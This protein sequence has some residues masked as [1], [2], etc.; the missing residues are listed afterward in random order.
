M[1]IVLIGYRG[2]GKSTVARLLS[3]QLQWPLVATDQEIVAE[4]G[5]SIPRIVEAHG[6]DHFRDL[7]ARIVARVAA[8]DQVVIDTGGGVIVRDENVELLRRNGVIV[9][10]KADLHTIAARIQDDTERPSL[11]GSK[12]FLE[13]IEEVLQERTPRYAK[14]AELAIDTGE[15]S[16][17]SIARRIFAHLEGRAAR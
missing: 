9:W 11:T 1:N 3:A 15:E 6:W 8:R 16:P 13:E 12:S 4:T 17:E 10:L 7:E 14:A 2:T 5:M